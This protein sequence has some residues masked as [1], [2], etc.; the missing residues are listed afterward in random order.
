MS[1][2]EIIGKPII[3][4][5]AYKQVESDN[6]YWFLVNK[7]ANKQD[8]KASLKAIYDVEPLSIRIINAPYKGR[9]NRKLVRRAVKKA[10]VRLKDGQRIELAA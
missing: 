2:Y 4:E 3:T 8:V 9:A 1:P 10:I 6:T 7:A 5:K